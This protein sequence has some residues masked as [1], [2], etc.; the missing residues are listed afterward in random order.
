MLTNQE[1][2]NQWLVG[3]VDGDGSFI[4]SNY[5]KLDEIREK[6]RRWRTKIYIFKE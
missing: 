1:Y 2:F 6:V 4:I 5:K 3:L